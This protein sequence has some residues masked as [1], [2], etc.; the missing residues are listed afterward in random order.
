MVALGGMAIVLLQDNMAGM[1]HDMHL[2]TIFLGIIAIVLLASIVVACIGG[3]VGLR[4]IRKGEEMAER[5]FSTVTP[6]AEKTCSLVT[7]LSPKIHS[8]TENVE[9][10]SFTV[11]GKVDE[12]SETVTQLNRTV[13]EV[14]NRTRSQ[15]ERVDGMV[16]GVLTTAQEVSRTVQEG[17]RKPVHQIAGLIA[18]VRVGLETLLDRSPFAR[19]GPKPTK[20]YE[21]PYDM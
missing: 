3:L 5:M 7:E 17:I 16:T 20:P 8:L 11:R 6:L 18:G 15:V 13:Q 21:S 14:N 12:L 4:L 1:Q 9:Q 10:I 2:Q 19:R